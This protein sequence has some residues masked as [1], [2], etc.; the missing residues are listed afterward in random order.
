MEQT[1]EEMTKER[2]PFIY[3]VKNRPHIEVHVTKNGYRARKIFPYN[4]YP[5]KEDA[6]KAA[7]CY[8]DEHLE[9]ALKYSRTL[10][11]PGNVAW[12]SLSKKPK[13]RPT[14]QFL[15]WAGKKEDQ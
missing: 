14:S 10:P 4:L 11:V 13:P 8:K 3:V 7:I 1:F 9:M 5:T 6:L 15:L 2:I 12:E